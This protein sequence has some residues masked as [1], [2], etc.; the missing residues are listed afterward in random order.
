MIELDGL[1]SATE[2]FSNEIIIS[3]NPESNFPRLSISDDVSNYKVQPKNLLLKMFDKLED[4]TEY[5]EKSAPF[6]GKIFHTFLEGPIKYS[7]QKQ[8]CE[9][10]TQEIA[11]EKSTKI[12][13]PHV[14]LATSPI[15][16]INEVSNVSQNDT[17]KFLQQLRNS[18]ANPFSDCFEAK[19][20]SKVVSRQ[21]VHRAFGYNYTN[22]FSDIIKK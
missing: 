1:G 3:P 18:C 20:K 7:K 11:V 19:L 15:N 10:K 22:F 9:T 14:P 12:E 5:L 8:I 2:S 4:N 6:I 21:R 17:G 16:F 13:K